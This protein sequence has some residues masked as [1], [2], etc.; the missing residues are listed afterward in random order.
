MNRHPT[1]RKNPAQ[2][3]AVFGQLVRAYTDMWGMPP[4]KDAVLN[5]WHHAKSLV[6]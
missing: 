5:A 3:L 6:G 1:P 4:D 2:L